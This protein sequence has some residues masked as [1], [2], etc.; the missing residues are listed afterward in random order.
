MVVV[1]GRVIAVEAAEGTDAILQRCIE[2][3]KSQRVNWDGNQGVLAKFVKPGQDFR[4]DLP[5]I[6]PETV[7]RVVAAKLAGIVVS[8]DSVLVVERKRTISMANDA[9][10]FIKGI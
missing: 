5:T 4:V 3:R 10:I 9:N 7:K 6:G 8:A 2:L 1:D